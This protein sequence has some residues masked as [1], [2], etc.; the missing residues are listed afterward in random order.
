M[1]RDGIAV[2]TR[3]LGYRKRRMFDEDG[4]VEF[5]VQAKEKGIDIRIALNLER[6]ARRDELTAA[7]IYSQDQD[8][9]EVVSEIEAI[10]ELKGI[11]IKLASAF[12]TGPASDFDRGIDRTQW[13]RF[14]K[15]VYDCCHN[16]TDYFPRS[17]CKV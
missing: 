6:V 7:I 8:L 10:G 16:K 13:L 3:S 14:D 11:E 2:T 12:A 4:D 9:N 5:M 17:F 15:Q 1:V